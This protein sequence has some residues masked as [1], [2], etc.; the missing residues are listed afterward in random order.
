ME[1]K[2]IKK[3]KIKKK[4]IVTYIIS[5]LCLILCLYITI[6]I[7]SANTNKRPPNILGVSVSYVPTSSM[8]PTIHTGDYVMFTMVNVNDIKTGSGDITKNHENKDGDIIVFY[9]KNEDKFIIHR[10]VGIEENSTG[11]YFITWGDNNPKKDSEKVSSD[12]VRGR[13]VTTLSF[14]GIFKGG[15]NTNIIFVILVVFVAVYYFSH[16]ITK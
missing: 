13:F 4:T 8:E 9:S 15:I 12:M 14:M 2:E 10:V 6:E 7:I 11:R 16:K 1:E 3:K 5:I